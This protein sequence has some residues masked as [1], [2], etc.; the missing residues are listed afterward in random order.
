MKPVYQTRFGGSSAPE[1]EQGN[2]MQAAL[3]S[4]FEVLLE[5]A[6]DFTG[7]IVNGSWYMHLDEWLA[8]RNLE[9][10]VMP[11]GTGISPVQA[12]YIQCV[13]STTLAAGDGHI[14]VA[15]NGKVVHDPNPRAKALGDFEE[16]WFF[17]AREPAINGPQI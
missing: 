4:I 16:S 9:L 14:V 17:A 11:A 13:K 3:A 12:H 15:L 2:C 6:P 10:I 7:E 5:D 8:T 1:G